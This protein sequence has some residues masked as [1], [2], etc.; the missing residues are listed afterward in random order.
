MFRPFQSQ[1]TSIRNNRYAQ[2][3]SASVSARKKNDGPR[4]LSGWKEIANYLGKG[5]R[6]VQRYERYLGFPVRRPAGRSRAAVIATKAELDAWVAASP[7]R[8][9][10][11]LSRLTPAVPKPQSIASAVADMHR[12]VKQTQGLRDDLKLWV[13]VLANTIQSLE[14]ETVKKRFDATLAND[15][16]AETDRLYDL[17][18][19]HLHNQRNPR[20]N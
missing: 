7:I 18:S 9:E 3:K 20:P 1:V 12:L 19:P 2:Q 10:F 8:Q 13:H 14:E 11:R 16:Q 4:F 15:V 5:V 6:T 17:L